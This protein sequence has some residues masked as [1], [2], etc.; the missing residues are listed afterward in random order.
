MSPG[1]SFPDTCV[2][3][4]GPVGMAQCR[5]VLLWVSAPTQS[6]TST[7]QPGLEHPDLPCALGRQQIQGLSE[8]KTRGAEPRTGTG[9][10]TGAGIWSRS[11]G[12]VP[13]LPHCLCPSSPT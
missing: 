10:G 1:L 7:A 13:T 8:V 5:F 4:Q 6:P 2:C 11:P 12:Q 9:A 3:S